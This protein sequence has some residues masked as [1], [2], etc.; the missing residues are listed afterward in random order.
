[1]IDALGGVQS[2][3]VLGGG[4]EIALA[5]V[6]KLIDG[7]CRSVTLAGRDTEALE[8]AGKELE[9]TGASQRGRRGVRRARLRLA[10]R[11]HP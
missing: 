4:S 3:L 5:T 9:A 1:M 8:R 11:V 10:R 2:V 6:R 7:R